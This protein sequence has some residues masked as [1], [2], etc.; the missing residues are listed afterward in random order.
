MKKIMLLKT[1]LFQESRLLRLVLMALLPIVG[2]EFVMATTYYDHYATLELE[3]RPATGAGTVYTTN[4]SGGERIDGGGAYNTNNTTNSN[5][6]V[7]IKA[8]YEQTTEQAEHFRFIGWSE[9][10]EEPSSNWPPTG[11]LAQSGY[12][13]TQSAAPDNTAAT[14]PSKTLYGYFAKKFYFNAEA[15][16]ETGQETMGEIYISYDPAAGASYGSTSS[17]SVSEFGSR[18]KTTSV[19]KTL[20]LHAKAKTGHEFLGWYQDGNKISEDEEYEISDESSYDYTN[21]TTVTQGNIV[22]RFKASGAKDQPVMLLSA[23][24]VSYD[25]SA[26]IEVG[27]GTIFSIGLDY[28]PDVTLSSSNISNPSGTEVLIYDGE[29]QKL[30]V[31]RAGTATFTI[32]QPETQ[33][34]AGKTVVFTIVAS[35]RVPQWEFTL[36]AT[37]YERNGYDCPVRLIDARPE[38]TLTSSNESVFATLS[39]S[40]YGEDPTVLLGA[41]EGAAQTID[42]T[43]HQEGNYQYEEITEVKQVTVLPQLTR[44]PIDGLTSTIAE[45][46]LYSTYNCAKADAII[47]NGTQY[48]MKGDDV[49]KVYQ[50]TIHF[51]GI[52]DEFSCKLLGSTND[53]FSHKTMWTIEESANGTNW[54]DVFPRQKPGG[55]Q[56]EVG[57]LSLKPTT[58]YL[59]W[60]YED[61]V[62][63]KIAN[64]KITE[65]LFSS[66]P[67]FLIYHIGD[68][69]PQQVQITCSSIKAL[70]YGF[71]AGSE[72]KFN[73]TTANLY[74]VAFDE[75]TK[76]TAD[77]S[78]L[79]SITEPFDAE[80]YVNLTKYGGEQKNVTVG[81]YVCQPLTELPLD[82]KTRTNDY[83]HFYHG[84]SKATYDKET[85]K[86]N[87]DVGSDSGTPDRWV[88]FQFDG[89]PG[90]ISFEPTGTIKE[91]AY[92]NIYEKASESASWTSVRRSALVRGASTPISVP[93]S[94]T[95]HYVRIEFSGSAQVASISNLKITKGNY[96]RSNKNIVSFTSNTESTTCTLTTANVNNLNVSMQNGTN[97]SASLS[98][99]TLTINRT[100]TDASALY[101]MVVITGTSAINN[102][103]I[104]KYIP[105]NTVPSTITAANANATGI[106][107]G[108]LQ[109]ATSEWAAYS[110]TVADINVA[111]AFADGKAFCDKIYI[112][113]KSYNETN[114]A[115]TNIA[116]SLNNL[117]MTSCHIYTKSGDNYVYNKTIENVCTAAK[118]SDFNIETS[119]SLKLY[120]T[121]YCPMLSVGYSGSD[122]SAIYIYGSGDKS[123]DIYFDNCFVVPRRKTIE[124]YGTAE[125]IEAY[126]YGLSFEFFPKGSAAAL[127]FKN[128]S[129]SGRLTANIHLK[130]RNML[131]SGD[132]M[133]FYIS[134]AKATHQSAPLM[135]SMSDT[136][137]KTTINIDDIWP[138]AAMSGSQRTNGQMMFNKGNDARP[139]IDLGNE[140]TI[141]NFNGGQITLR[142]AY[143]QSSTYKTTFAISTRQYEMSGAVAYGLGNDQSK[144]EINFNDGSFS[145]IK[146][147]SYGSNSTF[148]G[149]Y[150]DPDGNKDPTALRVPLQ[151]Y[152]NGGTFNCNVFTC[153]TVTSNGGSP[154]NSAGDR[155]CML[156]MRASG[157]VDE[158]GF[159]V[160]DF[161]Y[162]Q[163]SKSDGT[164]TLA[165]YYANK[166]TNYGHESITPKDEYVH[167]FLPCDYTERSAEMDYTVDIWKYALPSMAMSGSNAST[168]RDALGLP[169]NNLGGS[170]S[171]NTTDNITK[172]I[173]WGRI[174]DYMQAASSDY[175]IND[176]LAG[177]PITD[178]QISIAEGDY[179]SD[180]TNASEYVIK[181]GQYI[182]LTIKADK[183][184]SMCSPFAIK[185][186]YVV[187]SYPEDKLVELAE[188]NITN[189]FYQQGYSNIDY[190]YQ[191]AK[192][193]Y[194]TKENFAKVNSSYLSWSYKQDLSNG[195]TGS[196][197][198]YNWR[199]VKKITPYVDFQLYENQQEWSVD[200]NDNFTCDW[201]TA[202]NSDGVWM[203]KGRNYI[204]QFPAKTE[205][206]SWDYWTGKMIIFEGLGEETIQ[207]SNAHATI[208][209]SAT[210]SGEG[211]AVMLGNTTLA[212]L[213]VQNENLFYYDEESGMFLSEPDGPV[214]V[215]PAQGFLYAIPKVDAEA[216]VE[217]YGIEA[218]SGKCWYFLT[219][220]ENEI[221]VER[222]S[223]TKTY[224]GVDT[225]N[226]GTENNR[227]IYR[228]DAWVEMT[229]TDGDH[230]WSASNGNT[231]I[232]YADAWVIVTKTNGVY[233]DGAGNKYY[234]DET[235]AEWVILTGSCGVYTYDIYTFLLINDELVAVTPNAND[236]AY[237]VNGSDPAVYYLDVD[238]SCNWIAMNTNDDGAY[239]Y[240]TYPDFHFYLY[241]GDEWVPV[242][243]VL[244]NPNWNHTYI[245]ASSNYYISNSGNWLK[246]T[247]PDENH[248]WHGSD[249]LTYIYY[250]N[251]ADWVAVTHHE[252]EVYTDGEKFY[253][254]NTT[255]NKWETVVIDIVVESG[256]DYIVSGA[257][258]LNDLTVEATGE[259]ILNTGNSLR[260]H[261]LVI[262][263]TPDNNQSGIV[264]GTG[265]ESLVVEGDAYLDITMNSTGEMDASIYYSFAV[266][267]AVNRSNGVQRKNKN[268]GEWETAAIGTHY[269]AY[270][271]DEYERATNGPS[272]ACW[273][274]V[275]SE[276]YVPGKFYLCE[277]DNNNYNVYRFK[278]SDK[279]QLNPMTDI[280]VTKSSDDAVNAGWN[281]IAGKGISY[282]ALNG[283]FGKMFALNS[284]ENAFNVELAHNATLAVGHAVFVQTTA[285]GT[286]TI[287]PTSPSL[288]P[289]RLRQR[290]NPEHC[291]RITESGKQ[292]YDDQ[293][294]VSAS[295]EALSEYVAGKDVQKQWMGTPKVARIWVVDYDGLRLA[296]NEAVL[297]EDQ[298]DCQLGISAPKKGE[299]VL[300]LQEAYED[301]TVYLT[302]NGTILANLT[303]GEYPISV[304][305]GETAGY[306]LRIVVKKAPN[307]A[308]DFNAAIADNPN[309][310]HKVIVNDVI[311]IIKNQHVYTTNGQLVK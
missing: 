241:F 281:G 66:K 295:E 172:N 65:L 177:Q 85:Q 71:S 230:A 15:K 55:A 8:C 99:N 27:V 238:G 29:N 147:S 252:G 203:E 284:A 110:Y 111:G 275:T 204:L 139:S 194:Y 12:S 294:F 153:E 98:G 6:N 211:K 201:G 229:D 82:V 186:I 9:S 62:N 92:W 94:P 159:A 47:E 259:V 149:Y 256:E 197:S 49:D 77:I 170:T 307:V 192:A 84:S 118:S 209:A 240:G 263:S 30:I 46:L 248:L 58:R 100:G 59:R 272:N 167:L 290:T 171:V 16:V 165:Q 268:T 68:V 70:D 279:N 236:A 113:D 282:T 299:Y 285:E 191:L 119:G 296:A 101:D 297:V 267:F 105:V 310:I 289:A 128:T 304:E 175:R 309:G 202:D 265:M 41:I 157:G 126:K 227:Y 53:G 142:N 287:A 247:G 52:P 34:I 244:D 5:V 40:E 269:L 301:A 130:G 198:D 154:T 187:E 69:T 120:F 196:Q 280:A 135:V 95:S 43:F 1:E 145:C 79:P 31:N 243:R 96:I 131:Y 36:P 76:A 75:S 38:W 182:L 257:Q 114:P 148:D 133:F 140:N 104:T 305:K 213:T 89:I 188:G 308:T 228:N 161:P 224:K 73:I 226:D 253:Q 292:K 23:G 215:Q 63:G 141:L 134:G 214:T 217:L 32:S 178:I 200:E 54:S 239:Y 156:D 115:S 117:A 258:I 13:V 122:E 311:Y 206:A 123:V 91:G 179:Y 300:A 261:N 19:T 163:V 180:V 28:A 25:G 274:R 173:L 78:I 121:G 143:P 112:F 254:Y 246:I 183:Y 124:G 262:E 24:G 273:K 138:N 234:Y 168:A 199:G 51:E 144:G 7:T 35:K 93:L 193:A 88:E 277:F 97:Y 102:A 116:A 48:L 164:T 303:L 293:L 249:L 22:A 151:T 176:E 150:R 271:Y 26:N 232:Y 11:E 72:D 136:G 223:E 251:P 306:G 50:L 81:L 45:P 64:L 103:T 207:G 10:A 189:A 184:I 185:N 18:Q 302:H 137:Q 181:D 42:L 195:Y 56:R 21:A 60:T 3:A 61:G 283:S 125:D 291:V 235:N 80:W 208:K 127:C 250:G 260:V 266:P 90:D 298:A 286:V 222:S 221:M 158:K 220:D 108:T 67:D 17:V 231:Y 106:K 174:D 210:P 129:W 74:P 33:T 270:E 219:Y 86:I 169:S 233:T 205:N 190:C 132:G 4:S 37:L 237:R 245:D 146:P 288:A 255:S 160:F 216:P 276:Q 2:V 107:T 166:S 44:L 57:P 162:D 152:I 225:N 109:D 87:F 155:V 278:A 20:Y 264:H 242:D 83:Y 212:D 39:Q 218:Y 14:G